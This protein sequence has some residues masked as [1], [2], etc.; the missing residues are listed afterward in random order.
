MILN[1]YG[2]SLKIDD[3]VFTVGGRVFANE[4]SEYSGL[5]GKIVEIRTGA[6]KE[7]DNEGID[8]YVS[9]EEPEDELIAELEARFSELYREPKTINE[10]ALDLVIMSPEMLDIIE[11]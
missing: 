1:K 9:F 4:S 8:I 3:R 6:D 10:I 2:E 5:Y 11:E 7:T